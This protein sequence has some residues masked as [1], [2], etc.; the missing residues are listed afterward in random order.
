MSTI[1]KIPIRPAAKLEEIRVE[2]GHVCHFAYLDAGSA[3]ADDEVTRTPHV[4]DDGA[5]PLHEEARNAYLSPREREN[6]PEHNRETTLAGVAFHGGRR[7]Q[8]LV[9]R[10]RYLKCI[11]PRTSGSSRVYVTRGKNHGKG[12][13]PGSRN[14]AVPVLS[15]LG[16]AFFITEKWS[17]N[18]WNLEG[19]SFG[20]ILKF[21]IFETAK[22]LSFFF[23]FPLTSIFFFLW[24]MI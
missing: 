15:W 23:F 12:V 21:A 18:L 16:S 19:E 2:T 7:A 14:A 11:P 3:G 13:C 5:G 4:W 6:V 24:K 10:R 22:V 9:H 20:Q 1:R 17:R 8:F